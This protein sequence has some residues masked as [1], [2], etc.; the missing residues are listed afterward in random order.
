[1]PR[2]TAAHPIRYDARTDL[3]QYVGEDASEDEIDAL[4]SEWYYKQATLDGEPL[5]GWEPYTHTLFTED[6]T[7]HVRLED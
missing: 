4:N 6:L 3:R 7:Y 5:Q 1:M 2:I